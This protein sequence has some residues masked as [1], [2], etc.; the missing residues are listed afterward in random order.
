MSLET[1]GVWQTGVWASTVW[2]ADVWREGEP[3]V[4]QSVA[5]I[6]MSLG[7]KTISTSMT[8]KGILM[9]MDM[10]KIREVH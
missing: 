2:A 4:A 6:L 8:S 9:S 1:A 5:A 3:V 10:P 7:A